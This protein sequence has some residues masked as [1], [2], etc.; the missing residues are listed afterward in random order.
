MPH[1]EHARQDRRTQIRFAQEVP[2][3]A[4]S[5]VIVACCGLSFM[6][7]RLVDIKHSGW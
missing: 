7:I 5:R 1:L 2:Q 4:R 3:Y 6:L